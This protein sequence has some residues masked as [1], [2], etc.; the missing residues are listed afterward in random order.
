MR[1]VNYYKVYKDG[2]LYCV[3]NIFLRYQAKHDTLLACDIQDAQYI[4]SPSGE[5]IWHAQWLNK[6]TDGAPQYPTIESAE[7]SEDE[8]RALLSVSDDGNLSGADVADDPVS[9][10]IPPEDSEAEEQ[11]E[12][13][14]QRKIEQMSQSCNDAIVSG[15]DVVLS[16]GNTHHFSLTIEDQLNLISLQGMLSS[17]AEAVPYHADGEECRYYSAE[18]FTAIATAVTNWKLYQESY[19]NSLRAYIQSMETMPELLAVEYG[20]EVPAEYQTVVL[21]Q[22]LAQTGGN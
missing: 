4:C 2:E 12:F 3:N 1:K 7:I 14:R 20:M 18:D 21:Q 13:I 8:Y 19:F 6:I 15:V 5:E 17:G 16:D 22:M 10:E 11:L 9:E